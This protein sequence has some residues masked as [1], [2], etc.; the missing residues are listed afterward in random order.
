MRGSDPGDQQMIA[1][2]WWHVLRRSW[3]FEGL[4]DEKEFGIGSEELIKGTNEMLNLL[5]GTFR[6]FRLEVLWLVRSERGSWRGKWH[7]RC[8]LKDEKNFERNRFRKIFLARENTI[9]K[10]EGANTVGSAHNWC[11][12]KSAF[13]LFARLPRASW[14]CQISLTVGH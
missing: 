9:T 13:W 2:C 6:V 14:C 4:E 11:F 1:V 5:G 3:V 10:E 8:T 12:C 7:L